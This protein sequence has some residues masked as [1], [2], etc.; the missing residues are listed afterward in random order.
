MA[1]YYSKGKH[2]S[3]MYKEHYNEKQILYN[4]NK[5]WDIGHYNKVGN[6]IDYGNENSPKNKISN[7][8]RQN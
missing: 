8:E 5:N 3:M 1:D 7:A 4:K 6:D 2:D